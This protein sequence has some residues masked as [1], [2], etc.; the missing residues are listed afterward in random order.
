MDVSYHVNSFHISQYY[1]NS[2]LYNSII[3]NYKIGSGSLDRPEW[4]DES[5]WELSFFGEMAIG[6][7]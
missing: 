2:K 4:K 6:K 3:S 7:E 5:D 1:K